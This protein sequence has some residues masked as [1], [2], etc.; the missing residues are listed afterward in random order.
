MYEESGGK[1][2][3]YAYMYEDDGT[4]YPYT[5]N[6]I[7]HKKTFSHTVT[8][9]VDDS[10]N[11]RVACSSNESTELTQ[12]SGILFT[13]Y[14]TLD[15]S[16]LAASFS[17]KPIVKL[18]GLNLTTKAA[19]KYVP[20]DFSCRPF[21][22]GIPT[23]RTLPVNVSATNKIGTLIVPFDTDLPS[24]LK[25]Y[26]CNSVSGDQLVLTKANSIEACKPYIVYAPSGYSGNLSGTAVLSN[27]SNVTDIFTDG[28][29]TGVLTGTT[30][31]TGYI[32]QNKNNGAGPLFYDAEGVTF[33]LPAGRCYLTPSGSS[34]K[35]FN[36]SFDD[37]TGI[38]DEIVKRESEDGAI[39]DLSGRRVSNPTNGIYIKGT[40]KVIVK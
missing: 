33:S 24:G 31:N 28:Y 15:N 2:V 32:L 11:L 39:Y 37:A 5:E 23:S 27:A 7:T 12:T 6:P 1:K 19:V 36:F 40:R 17:P 30:V 22:T 20:A 16:A 34:V 26:S 38:M 10:G 21:T 3:A 25:A 29:L 9:Q 14:V 18:S 8:G 4:I 13:V 35:A